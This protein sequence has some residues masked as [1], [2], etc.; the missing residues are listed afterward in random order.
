[1]TNKPANRVR[2]LIQ[3][4]EDKNEKVL[5]SSSP[6]IA[7]K[8]IKLSKLSIAELI[9]AGIMFL[10]AMTIIEDLPFLILAAFF[11]VVAFFETFKRKLITGFLRKR[12]LYAV[13]N[14]R[15][16]ILQERLTDRVITEYQ[17]DN[18]KW[19][20]IREANPPLGN[21]EFDKYTQENPAELSMKQLPKAFISIPEP[22]KVVSLIR[23]LKEKADGHGENT[24][25]A[26][27]VPKPGWAGFLAA[28]KRLARLFIIAGAAVGMLTLGYGVKKAAGMTIKADYKK[29]ISEKQ[30]LSDLDFVLVDSKGFVYCFE[31]NVAVNIYDPAGEFIKS[32]RIEWGYAKGRGAAD[33]IND[34]ICANSQA[35]NNDDDVFQYKYGEFQYH[36]NWK[37]LRII[38]V[39]DKKGNKC[40]ERNMGK[41]APDDYKI[42]A[43]LEKEGTAGVFCARD[44]EYIILTPDSEMKVNPDWEP[45]SEDGIYYAEDEQG[46]RYEIKKSRWNFKQKL[47]RTSKDGEV[48]VLDSCGFP[49]NSIMVFF[50]GEA[51]AV[52]LILAGVYLNGKYKSRK[53]Y[54][55]N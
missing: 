24:F 37:D 22:E 18:L 52:L 3:P 25:T 53:E 11:F 47:I 38:E 12:T 41:N 42:L 23:S 32:F 46:T 21:I 39:Y 34:N 14:K 13:T 36:I 6:E 30:K 17:L 40:F 43:Y 45:F 19:I 28:E 1:M 8:T 9:F 4:F 50:A 27:I 33:I 48:K 44:E 35:R 7:L 16:L 15:I 54:M 55:K 26:K 49:D 20:K 51:F 2:E 10:V 29:P 5:W 31:D